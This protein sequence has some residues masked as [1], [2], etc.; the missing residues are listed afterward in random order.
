M[1]H[2]QSQNLGD[3]ADLVM[4]RTPVTAIMDEKSVRCIDQVMWE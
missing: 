4:Y 1:I 3:S 2:G